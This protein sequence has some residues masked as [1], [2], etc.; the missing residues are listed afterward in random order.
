MSH[1]LHALCP[2]WVNKCKVVSYQFSIEESSL[3]MGEQ[4][5]II[6]INGKLMEPA[7]YIGK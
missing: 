4:L 6:Y 2:Q 7:K 5:D 3:M 1:Q